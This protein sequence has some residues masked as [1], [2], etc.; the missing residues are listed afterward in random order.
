VG[1]DIRFTVGTAREPVTFRSTMT[2][3]DVWS[4]MIRDTA[5]TP[6]EALSRAREI[7]DTALRNE[8]EIA[9]RR[10]FRTWFQEIE[11]RWEAIG[12]R[13]I[14]VAG[15]RA[16]HVRIVGNDVA[17]HFQGISVALSADDRT[18]YRVGV[19]IIQGNAIRLPGW[20][21]AAGR[22]E[23]IFIGNCESATVDENMVIV[24]GGVNSEP[25][26][27]AD[28]I[29]AGGAF[30]ARLLIRGNHVDAA[31]AGIRVEPIGAPPPHMRRWVASDNVNLGGACLEAPCA[32]MED[33]NVPARVAA[34]A[35][36]RP[37]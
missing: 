15:R 1:R 23:G 33:A 17:G 22:T 24:G 8:G 9:G 32:V 36:D 28:G 16:E 34:C 3:G 27:A 35:G 5:A 14:V 10:V 2:S 21:L 7:A 30:G 13:G 26:I 25:S 19:A 31:L 11:A 20:A 29:R 6:R 37:I 4:A 12:A 18:V